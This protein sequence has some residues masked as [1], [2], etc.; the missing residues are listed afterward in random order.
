[1]DRDAMWRQHK[2]QQADH[3]KIIAIQNELRDIQ[4]L[5]RHLQT[6]R[7]DLGQRI[8]E[9]EKQLAGIEGRSYSSS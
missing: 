6:M 5:L 7:T 9:L 1:M 2:Q 8:S 4:V 3:D